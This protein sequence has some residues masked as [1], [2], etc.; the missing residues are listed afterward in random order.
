LLIVED[1]ALV[2]DRMGK[3]VAMRA[4]L[5]GEPRK[6]GQADRLIMIDLIQ[7]ASRWRFKTMLYATPQRFAPL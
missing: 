3:N 2:Q 7:S 5:F 1:E 4:R 6:G